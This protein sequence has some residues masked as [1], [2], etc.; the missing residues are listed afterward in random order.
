[1]GV[2]DRSLCAHFFWQAGY[3]DQALDT[4]EMALALANEVSHPFSQAMALSFAAMLRQF[5]RE[6]QAARRTA[7]AALTLC[8]ERGFSYYRAWSTLIYGE[9]LLEDRQA[10]EGITQMRSGLE[11][12]QATGARLRRPYY[13][14]LLAQACC[15]VG[16]VEEAKAHLAEALALVD[17][18]GERWW[19]AELYRIQG[20]LL[21]TRMGN[22]QAHARSCFERALE[23]SR[24]QRARSLEL[25]AATSL[26]Q[27]WAEQGERQ[28]AHDLLAPVYG[29]FTEG[30]D[31]PDLKDAKALLDALR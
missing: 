6:T 18:S 7:A 31:T 20:K 5:R 1:M 25:R 15:R 29:W 16:K 21:L 30:F 22:G 26:A 14:G 24:Q 4:A 27:L 19:Q 3:I 10:E 13:L 28:K 2:F 12:M 23:I 11:A 17:K 9:T 8:D